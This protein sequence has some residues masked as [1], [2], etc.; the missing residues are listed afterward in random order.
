MLTGPTDFLEEAR[1]WAL[2]GMSRDSWNRYSKGGSWYY[3]VVRP[4]FKCNMTD[5]QA[6]LGL[7]QLERIADFQA[8]RAEVVR[9]YDEALAEVPQIETPT[10]TR[11]GATSALHLY[12][13]RLRLADLRI[14]RAEFIDE[15]AARNIGASVHFIPVHM[16]PYYRSTLGY[17]D[18]DLPVA[19]REFER[20]VSLPLNP[21]LTDD[22][23]E[24]V[25]AAVRDIIFTHVA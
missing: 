1:L 25:A 20:L 7:H 10:T 2:H 14:D 16:H 3:E 5:I 17:R 21:R 12:P 24:D 15:L 6:A 18:A 9:R 22:D 11:A 8:R 4:G 13:I 19:S 23:V